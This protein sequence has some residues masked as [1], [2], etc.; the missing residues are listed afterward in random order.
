VEHDLRCGDGDLRQPEHDAH[1]LD[2]LAAVHALTHDDVV[3]PV[4]HDRSDSAA[5]PPR[6]LATKDSASFG[7]PEWQ[8]GRTGCPSGGAARCPISAWWA[9]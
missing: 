8:I 9:R 1:L 7:P 4:H 3:L 2:Q 5:R 6:R